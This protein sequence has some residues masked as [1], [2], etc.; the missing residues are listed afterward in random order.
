MAKGKG[1]G[2]RRFTSF[3]GVKL[4]KN[5]ARVTSGIGGAE[6]ATMGPEGEPGAIRGTFQVMKGEQ[7]MAGMGEQVVENT[8]NKGVAGNVMSTVGGVLVASAPDIATAL[9]T[10]IKKALKG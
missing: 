9:V 8:V 3:G 6:I 1:K 2:K 10:R 7:T 4:V 5:I